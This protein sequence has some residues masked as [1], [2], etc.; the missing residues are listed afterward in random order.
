MCSKGR[1]QS[2]INVEP[3]KLLFDPY[4][5]TLH[6]DK[7]KVIQSKHLPFPFHWLKRY[8]KKAFRSILTVNLISFVA[9]INHSD[10]P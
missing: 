2:P 4:L 7:H 5:R 1:R 9:T 8:Q 3:E 6:I 10:T